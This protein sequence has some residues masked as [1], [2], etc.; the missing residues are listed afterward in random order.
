VAVWGPC[1][2]PRLADHVGLSGL[3]R[4]SSWGAGCLQLPTTSPASAGVVVPRYCCS[5]PRKQKLCQVGREEVSCFA[6]DGSSRASLLASAPS[7]Q[8]RSTRKGL[9]FPSWHLAW[10]WILL[11]QGFAEVRSRNGFKTGRDEFREG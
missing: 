10:W 1:F 7:S 3:V 9:G 4:D 8:L 5:V 2:S 11:P 6:Q